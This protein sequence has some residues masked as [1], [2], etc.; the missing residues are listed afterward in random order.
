VVEAQAGHRR[1]GQ[2]LILRRESAPEGRLHS[3]Y[4]KVIAGNQPSP[5]Q[6]CDIAAGC[7]LRPNSQPVEVRS[8]RSHVLERLLLLAQAS[9]ERV[10]EDIPTPCLPGHEPAR[11]SVAV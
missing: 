2:M 4:R 10:G 11:S 3:K 8:K 9:I 7:P 5:G 1:R 6:L